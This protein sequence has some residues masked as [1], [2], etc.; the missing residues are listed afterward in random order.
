MVLAASRDERTIGDIQTT[1]ARQL[2]DWWL[3]GIAAIAPRLVVCEKCNRH[4][5][6]LIKRG[7]GNR[8]DT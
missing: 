2:G 7:G 5:N 8:T 3:S 1:E 6:P 4:L